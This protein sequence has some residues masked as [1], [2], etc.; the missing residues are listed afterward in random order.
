[1]N[2]CIVAATPEAVAIPSLVI[3]QLKDVMTEH[4]Y[5]I[6][7]NYIDLGYVL[8]NE[9]SVVALAQDFHSVVR[10]DASGKSIQGTFL[11]KVNTWKDWRLLSQYYSG[12]S[13]GGSHVI[14]H[15]GLRGTPMIFDVI[16]ATINTYMPYLNTGLVKAL[17]GSTRGGAELEYLIGKPGSGLMAMNSFSIGTYFVLVLIILGNIGYYGYKYERKREG[18]SVNQNEVV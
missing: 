18:V 15:F 10:Q 8:P 17:L 13:G 5:V 12:A 9:P 11:D 4:H 6:G 7:Q 1:V 16:G 3:D 2:L 14:Q